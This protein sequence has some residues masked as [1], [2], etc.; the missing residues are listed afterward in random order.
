MFPTFESSY[1]LLKTK[2]IKLQLILHFNSQECDILINKG[3][4]KTKK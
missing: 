3:L 4:S 1:S 2:E